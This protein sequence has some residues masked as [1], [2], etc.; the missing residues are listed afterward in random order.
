MLVCSIRGCKGKR[1]SRGLCPK[2]Y[3]QAMNGKIPLP[4]IEPRQKPP[5][6]DFCDLCHNTGRESSYRLTFF[7]C[8]LVLCTQ[9]RRKK[10]GSRK[11]GCIPESELI[12]LM[13]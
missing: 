2:H 11:A 6:T 7:A 8:G 10:F 4:P 5:E 3:Y 1:A 13:K 12:K 9:C